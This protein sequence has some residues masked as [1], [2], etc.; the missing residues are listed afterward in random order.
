MQSPPIALIT[1]ASSGI[2]AAIANR[3]VQDG[4]RVYGTSRRKLPDADNGLRFLQMDVDS[5][6]SVR[7]AVQTLLE[8]EKRIDVLVNC[9]G[10][11]MIA[12]LEESPIGH[13]RKLMETNF[14]GAFRLCQAVL[15]AMR[16]QQSGWIINVSSIIGEVGLPFRGIYAA[17]KFALE[18]M[19]ESL[20]MEVAAFNIRVALL[21]PGDFKTGIAQNRL[22]VPRTVN[23]PYAEALRVTDEIIHKGMQSA[24]GPE[25]TGEAI[26]RLLRRPKPGL[27]LRVGALLETITPVM[28]KI[29]PFRWYERMVMRHY[30]M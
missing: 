5:E 17:S 24:P 29:L 19:T 12:P 25:I 26:S 8:Q 27:R 28:K 7:Q 14:F 13:V 30:G 21:Q 22:E 11:G 6:E 9:A 15:P 20:R 23:S 18:G 10:L 1:G 2:G 4:Y 16:A 3:L